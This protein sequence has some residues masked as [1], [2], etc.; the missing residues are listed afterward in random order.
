M[1]VQTFIPETEALLLAWENGSYASNGV[2]EIGLDDRLL[3]RRLVS[4]P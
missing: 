3:R 4:E 1:Q 2:A